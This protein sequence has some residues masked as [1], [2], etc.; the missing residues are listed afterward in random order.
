MNKRTLLVAA[1]LV[2]LVTAC[3]GQAASPTP[4]ATPQSTEAPTSSPSPTSAAE[5]PTDAPDAT[6]SGPATCT[7]EPLV[8]PANEEIPPV[9]EDDHRHGPE[10]APITFI[11][12]ADFQ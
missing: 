1:L 4:S 5:A 8:F 6:P 10:D 12:Y 3:S 11:E 9:T 2:G 7:A